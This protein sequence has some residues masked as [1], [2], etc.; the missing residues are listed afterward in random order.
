MKDR[1]MKVSI[2]TNLRKAKK[3][4]RLNLEFAFLPLSPA[5][6]TGRPATPGPGVLDLSM[7][8][9]ASLTDVI[10]KSSDRYRLTLLVE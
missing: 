5:C 1:W 4:M 8:S 6:R 3:N 10:K 7:L 2:T 9:W